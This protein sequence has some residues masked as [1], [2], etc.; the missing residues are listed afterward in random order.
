[1]KELET[2]RYILRRPKV[3]DAEQVY[4]K[5]GKDNEEMVEYKY[6][7][8]YKS[9]KKTKMIIEATL[10]ETEEGIPCWFIEKKET[11]E[12]VGYVKVTEYSDKN[13]TA[14]IKFY[15]LEGWRLEGTPEEVLTKIFEYLFNDRKFET[16][17]ADH[18]YMSE[19][20]TRDLG[21]VLTNVGMT[22]EAVLRNRKIN[23]KGQ[24]V[25]RI[26]YSILKEE[27]EN[28]A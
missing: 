18:Y 3:E 16:V 27:W 7:A 19:S 28:I 5:W 15:F 25:D 23:S 10:H 2:E 6:H 12:I 17:I 1:M 4:E 21:R 26:I 14:V 13:K 22:K 11:R 20:H 24:K 8:P 9:E